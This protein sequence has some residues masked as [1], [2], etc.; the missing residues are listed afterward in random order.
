MSLQK[1]LVEDIFQQCLKKDLRI[2]AMES[3]TGGLISGAITD[4]PGSSKIF[5]KGLITYSNESKVE[6]LGVSKTNIDTFG[7][8][9]REV[10]TEMATKLIIDTNLQYKVSIATSGVAGPGKS[11]Q[12]PVG[13]V[14]LA[15]YKY[16]NLIVKKINFGNISRYKIRKK[17]VYEALKLLQKNLRD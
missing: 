9:S 14:W 3:R 7:A 10:V 11:E 6:L 8:V 4:I 15:S 13:L 17:T 2:I 5:D 16:N 1:K 12:K